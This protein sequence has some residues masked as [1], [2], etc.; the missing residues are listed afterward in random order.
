MVKTLSKEGRHCQND[1]CHSADAEHTQTHQVLDSRA[2]HK[3]HRQGNTQQQQRCR[4]VRLRQDD[5]R[6]CAKQRQIT[7]RSQPQL[8]HLVLVATHQVSKQQNQ[9]KFG[10][11]RRLKVDGPMRTQRFAPFSASNR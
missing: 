8:I 4:Q 1:D 7:R 3:H 10:N 2:A 9:R 11:L 6:H 5:Q